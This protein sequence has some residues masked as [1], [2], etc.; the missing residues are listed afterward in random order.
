MD[1][2]AVLVATLLKLSISKEDLDWIG[3]CVKETI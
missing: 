1:K 3:D 2:M